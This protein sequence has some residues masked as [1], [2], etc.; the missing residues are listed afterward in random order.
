MSHN[1][2][3]FRKYLLSK[4]E[5]HN[6]GKTNKEE[7][8][9]IKHRSSPPLT[10]LIMPPKF[11]SSISRPLSLLERHLLQPTRYLQKSLTTQLTIF[12]AGVVNVY[13]NVPS[14]KAQAI[15]LL[16]GESC[17]TKP[18]AKEKTL[19]EAKAS[20]NQQQAVGNN[21]NIHLF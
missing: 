7:S 1:I 6:V 20:P 9:V 2:D 19:V 8:A 15:M 16:A 10:P 14:D 21:F 4:S 3:L 11:A 18:T 12:Y 13:D 17:V 5:N